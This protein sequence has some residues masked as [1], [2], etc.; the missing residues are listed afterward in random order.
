MLQRNTDVIDTSKAMATQLRQDFLYMQIHNLPPIHQT[1]EAVNRAYRFCFP[2]GIFCVF[3][4]VADP[5]FV[6]LA[7][8]GCGCWQQNNNPPRTK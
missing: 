8:R 6:V 5:K 2:P 4:V 7:L 1:P 3:V